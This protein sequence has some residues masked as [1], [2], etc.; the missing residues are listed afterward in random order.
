MLPPLWTCCGWLTDYEMGD[1]NVR[2]LCVWHAAVVPEY[3][4]RFRALRRIDR[5]ID[6]HVLV[7]DGSPEGGRWAVYEAHDNDDYHIYQRGSLF[8]RHP[9]ALVYRTGSRW[10]RSLRP[11]IVHVHEEPWSM[12]AVQMLA[13]F[14]GEAPT[15]VESWENVD[16]PAKWPFR[17]V[18][19]WSHRSATAFIAG[20][21][22]V[23]SVLKAR[24][25]AKPI[26]VIPY[27]TEIQP[28]SLRTLGSP[29]RIGYVGRCVEEKGIITLLEA[30]KCSSMDA[31]YMFIGDGPLV[32]LLQAFIRTHS[33]RAIRWMPSL[34]QAQVLEAI[35][36]LD[37]L[38]LP[39][40]TT[41]VWSEQFGRVLVEA[42][43]VGT[44]PVGSD[45]GAIPWVIG[46]CG[47]VFPVG[48]HRGLAEVLRRLCSDPE[49]WLR[50]SCN[51][52]RR[53]RETFSWDSVGRTLL[54]FYRFVQG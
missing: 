44:V 31:E 53:I 11:D 7:P 14:R 45:S 8:T 50:L 41:P 37:I 32:P 40:M 5:S 47:G 4:E 38:V 12:A 27:G 13:A 23:E 22:Q 3:R 52:R 25:V 26:A 54:E 39:S 6:L 15:V 36:A 33:E 29:A 16:R 46:A 10:L 9:N 51:G 30:I 42:M 18:E 43:S 1:A 28:I 49:E 19:R 20:T 24:G 21:P 35:R 2:V 17:Y 48:D 34:P